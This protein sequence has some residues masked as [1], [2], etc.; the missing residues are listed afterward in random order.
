MVHDDPMHCRDRL[1]RIL[2]EPGHRS[3]K[4]TQATGHGVTRRSW[5]A[6][7]LAPNFGVR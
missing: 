4:W 7:A 5:R 6:V 2:M 1:T 3:L